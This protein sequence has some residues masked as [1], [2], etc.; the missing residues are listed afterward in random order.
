MSADLFRV[1]EPEE[2][3]EDGYPFA[4]HGK[5]RLLPPDESGVIH[6]ER[7]PA[8]KDMV[9]EQAGNRCVRCLHPYSKGEGEWSRCDTGC[10]HAGPYRLLGRDGKWR[11][12][13]LDVEGTKA[14]RLH[15]INGTRVEA[16]WRVL[17]VH[18]LNGVKAD[19]R[20]WNLGSLCQRCHLRI[21]RTVVMPRVFPWEHTA[22]FKPYA[23]G[24]YAFAYLGLD[25]SRD[26]VEERLDELLMLERVA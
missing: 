9:R 22:W 7:L 23:A 3:G 10:Q 5:R 12:G 26:E 2:C 21:Q 14:P 15:A 8:I 4:W 13:V 18:H 20:W 17:T 11:D 6:G 25:L 1:Y 19:L 24:W 16:Q